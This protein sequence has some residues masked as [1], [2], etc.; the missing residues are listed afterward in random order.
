LLHH[1][2]RSV[3]PRFLYS[4]ILFEITPEGYVPAD[5][6]FAIDSTAALELFMGNRLYSDNRVFLRELI[7]NAVD[8]CNLKKR[9]VS[10][11]QPEITVAFNEDISIITVSDNGIGMSRQWIEKYFLKI[12]ISFYQ[13]SEVRT[14]QGRARLD[15]NFISQFGIGF[16]SGFLVAEKI[17]IRTRRTPDPGMAITIRSVRDYFDVM[18]TSDDFDSGTE[19]QLH[20]KPSRI[21]YCR[22]LEYIG[23]L[24][25]NIRFLSIPVRFIDERGS[26]AMLGLEPLSYERGDRY[27]I[28]F[29]GAIPLVDAEGYLLMRAKKQSDYIQAIEGAIGGISI[30]QDGI[31]V[32]QV[33]HL[34]PE[35]ARQ[36]VVGRINLV[37]TDKCE[38]SMDRNR[39][40]WTDDQLRN[41]KRAIRHALVDVANRFLAAVNAQEMP[42]NIRQSIINHLAIFFDFNEVDDAMHRQL[43]EPVRR[44]VDKRFRDFIRIHFAHALKTRGAPAADGYNEG[45]QRE[46][47]DAFSEKKRTA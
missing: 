43:G 20:L 27:G 12:G 17:V 24:K 37:G 26:T 28:D 8:A 45:W 14:L 23:Y 7:Q 39:I 25:T 22:S 19:V 18:E 9:L 10:D 16:L 11:Y 34:L 3:S 21:N 29:I 36:N 4:D 15:F 41:L 38:L 44:I 33:D 13:S 5:L 42:V 31:F 40:F 35:G 6:K 32:T 1:L 30:F 47:I 46:I 2:N